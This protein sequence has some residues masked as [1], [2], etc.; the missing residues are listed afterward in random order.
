MTAIPINLHKLQG[1]AIPPTPGPQTMSSLADN[2]RDRFAGI[3][4]IHQGIDKDIKD[5]LTDYDF[6]ESYDEH[7]SYSKRLFTAVHQGCV[8]NYHNYLCIVTTNDNKE[9]YF[10]VAKRMRSELQELEPYC[11]CITCCSSRCNPLKYIWCPSC[12]KCLKAGP[13]IASA[14]LIAR[15]K[16]LRLAEENSR[17]QLRKYPGFPSYINT[18][19]IVHGAELFAVLSIMTLLYYLV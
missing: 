12:T 13:G 15:A 4:W 7:K 9:E 16:E 8:Q 2:A 6:V 3:L 19:V 11:T 1:H 14:E 10:V 17:K 18:N 5:Y